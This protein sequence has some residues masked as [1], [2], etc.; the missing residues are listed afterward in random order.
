MNVGGGAGAVDEH[1]FPK[2]DP[3]NSSAP[4]SRPRC[5]IP[6]NTRE[7]VML[8]NCNEVYFELR[9]SPRHSGSINI[10]KVLANFFL[11][12]VSCTITI[13]N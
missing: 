7:P 10:Q 4:I 11:D 8:R 12:F 2:V 6:A 3:P 1:P 5:V 13:D 9:Q